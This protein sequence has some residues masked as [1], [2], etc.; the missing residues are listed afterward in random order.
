MAR[1]GHRVASAATKAKISASLRGNKNAYRGG[2]KKRLTA[3]EKV[4]NINART[5]ANK[6]NLS[7]AQIRQRSAVAKRLRARARIE[8]AN[9]NPL[10]SKGIPKPSTIEKRDVEVKEN[11]NRAK[12]K[13]PGLEQKFTRNGRGKQQANSTTAARAAKARGQNGAMTMGHLTAVDRRISNARANNRITVDQ[14]VQARQEVRRRMQERVSR[15]TA[16]RVAAMNNG[17]SNFTR[18]TKPGATIGKTRNS[19][20]MKARVTEMNNEQIAGLN[21]QI[22]AIER[23]IQSGAVSRQRGQ[24]EQ[25]QLSDKIKNLRQHNAD[26]AQLGKR[27]K[28]DRT[29]NSKDVD[30]RVKSTAKPRPLPKASGTPEES[31]RR[32]Y[33]KLVS[34]PEGFVR[35]SKLKPMLRGS[36]EEQNNTLLSMTRS[37]MVHLVQQANT[38][39]LTPD[40]HFHAIKIGSE[41][42]HLIAIEDVYSPKPLPRAE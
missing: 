14:A 25:L 34:E 9:G 40:D 31:V 5:K 35:L 24:A 22:V 21:S 29:A 13:V 33:N 27:K 7:D 30:P 20:A 18:T 15:D 42:K 32:A 10:N 11:V 39:G 38:K 16:K 19:A 36:A 23:S 17:D 2:P 41:S 1:G 6:V 37:G 12:N 8:E 4:A 28:A 3:R 26:I